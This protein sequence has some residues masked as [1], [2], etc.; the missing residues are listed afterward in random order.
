MR[1]I[2]ILLSLIIL[3]TSTDYR[4]TAEQSDE[5]LE[6]A[7]FMSSEE[8]KADEEDDSK[9]A[10][11]DENSTN[12][13]D[14]GNDDENSDGETETGGNDDENSV[15]GSQEEASPEDENTEGTEDG[16]EE[17][18]EDEGADTENG[19][20]ENDATE[21]KI[22]FGGT[23]SSY[24][25]DAS[26]E[27]YSLL[28]N[29]TALPSG[30]SEEGYSLPYNYS[31]DIIFTATAGTDSYDS[32]IN[33]YYSDSIN[34]EN[35]STWSGIP[36][37]GDYYLYFNIPTE[38]IAP[39][40]AV[41]NYK[42]SVIDEV[43][44]V[45]TNLSISE[46]NISI[47]AYDEGAGLSYYALSTSESAQ[48]VDSWTEVTGAPVKGTEGISVSVDYAQEEMTPGVYY[49]YVKDASGNIAKSESPVYISKLILYG[50]YE[51]DAETEYIKYY[52]TTDAA[53]IAAGT[54]SDTLPAPVRSKFDF[55]GFYED[56]EYSSEVI[57]GAS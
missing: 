53:A 41:Y 9:S 29:G 7:S 19:N 32:G 2:S 51:N 11:I 45:I 30:D 56:Q 35:K 21:E 43:D 54:V 12:E 10:F 27:D 50:Y 23:V 24:F 26:T 37:I 4:V 40:K 14:S 25:N 3:F 20:E 13:D 44:P 22:V 28:L 17:G 55:D 33:V 18:S 5:S 42:I 39:D 52:A 46:E 8:T 15:D 36:G 38:A 34:F 6:S 57:A 31:E 49:L 1:V 47:S 48:S 16:I